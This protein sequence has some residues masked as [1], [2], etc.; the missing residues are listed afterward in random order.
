MAEIIYM[1]QVKVKAAEVIPKK[2]A[3][4]YNGHRFILSFN[5]SSEPEKRWSWHVKFTRTYDFVGS[6]GT[7]K[8]AAKAAEKQIDELEG[9]SSSAAN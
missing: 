7:I 8:D 9:R 2:E 3:R 6:A 1:D 4:T 5:P